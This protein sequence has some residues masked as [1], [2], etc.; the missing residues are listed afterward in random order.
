MNAVRFTEYFYHLNSG[1]YEILPIKER[2]YGWRKYI[3]LTRDCVKLPK[4]SIPGACFLTKFF[5]I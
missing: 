2:I 3:R 4:I 1:K 5:N